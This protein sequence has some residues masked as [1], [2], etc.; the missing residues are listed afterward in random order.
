MFSQCFRLCCSLHSVS[1]AHHRI[2]VI[3]SS[4][5]TLPSFPSLPKSTRSKAVSVPTSEEGVL[6]R[7]PLFPWQGSPLQLVPCPHPCP[8]NRS[9]QEP[10]L[11]FPSPQAHRGCAHVCACMHTHTYACKLARACTHTHVGLHK[12][13][14][15]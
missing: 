4:R 15:F 2:S 8:S 6:L 7:L 12:E 10:Q 5:P 1:S 11:L 14:T 9:P 3:Y 13:Q